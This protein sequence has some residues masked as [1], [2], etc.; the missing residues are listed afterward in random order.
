MSLFEQLGR[1]RAF[2]LVG[3]KVLPTLDRAVCRISRGRATAVGVTRP[4]IVLVTVGAKSG[5]ERRTPLLTLRRGDRYLVAGSNWGQKSH[6]AWTANLLADPHAV[7]LDRG[8]DVPVTARLLEDE[9]EH[10]RAYDDLIAMWPAYSD[11]RNRAG[12]R[13][14]RVFELTRRF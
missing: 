13:H 5:E 12:G 7:V 1:T 10:D 3:R 9:E 8:H 2:A 4:T 11:Y 14:I 6:P